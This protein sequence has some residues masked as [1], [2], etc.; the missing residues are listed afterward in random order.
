M[1]DP[2]A[3][4]IFLPIEMGLVA[5]RDVTVV[6]GCHMPFFATDAMILTMETGGLSTTDLAFFPFLV[7]TPVLVVQAGVDLGAAGMRL[8]PFTGP[9][10]GRG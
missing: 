10:K 4:P 2:A 5:S 1:A 8:I 3:D 6:I 7:D 9:G